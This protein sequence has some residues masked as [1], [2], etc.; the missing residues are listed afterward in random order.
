MPFIAMRRVRVVMECSW[1]VRVVR[2]FGYLDCVLW[3]ALAGSGRG[4]SGLSDLAPVGPVVLG[5]ARSAGGVPE[6]DAGAV[7][8]RRAR[9]HR[10]AG[11]RFPKVRAP[12]WLAS[13]TALVAAVRPAP[14]AHSNHLCA[15]EPVYTVVRMRKGGSS[16]PAG[17]RAGGRRPAGAGPVCGR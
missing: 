13:R 3:V 9:Q 11:M 10:Q 5:P 15:L 14:T 7:D 17:R 4:R 6:C 1:V 8:G 12:G 2:M 16:G